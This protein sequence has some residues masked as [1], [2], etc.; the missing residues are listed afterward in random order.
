MLGLVI[1]TTHAR[2]K[3]IGVRKILGASVSNIVTI[4]SKDFVKLVLIAFVIAAPAAWWAVYNWLQDYA[5][6]T[7]MSWWIFALC[8][9]FMLLIALVTLSI[10]TI[11]A[12][13][14]NPVKSLRTE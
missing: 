11:K 13:V 7:N 2:T 6:K 1:Y 8:G 4:L 12:A 9:L 10:Q 5:Y 3:E 14:T